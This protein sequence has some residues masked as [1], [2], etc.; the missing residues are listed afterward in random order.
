MNCPNLHF[1]PIQLFAKVKIRPYEPF[2]YNGVPIID[3]RRAWNDQP[4]VADA[5]VGSDTAAKPAEQQ[6]QAQQQLQQ[7]QQQQQLQQPQQQQQLLPP[8]QQQ[9]AIQQQQLQQGQHQQQQ[10]VQQ[11]QQ[12]NPKQEQPQ[13]HQPQQQSQQQPNQVQQPQQQQLMLQPSETHL[14]LN[15]QLVPVGSRASL[16]TSVSPGT[17]QTPLE[18]REPSEIPPTPSSNCSRSSAGSRLETN[19]PLFSVMKAPFIRNSLLIS[20]FD[21]SCTWLPLST[22]HQPVADWQITGPRGFVLSS[23]SQ[24]LTGKAWGGC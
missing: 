11:Q 7:P 19:Q 22:D 20:N 24:N 6:Q 14:Q 23:V 2:K 15:S 3:A 12:Q 13:Q 17:P 8:L 4:A 9:P 16:G 5:A 10:Q 21:D 18:Q 1:K